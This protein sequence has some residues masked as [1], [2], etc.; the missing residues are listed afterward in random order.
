MLGEASVLV[1]GAGGLGS[2][3]LLYLAAAGIGQIGVIDDDS[4]DISNLQRQVLHDTASVGDAKV[5]S[6][7]RRLTELNPEIVIE[8]HEARLGV[9]NALGLIGEYDV[10]IDGSDNFSTRYLIGDVCEILGRPWVFG[11]IHRF[12]GQ[13]AT[14]NFDGSPNYRDLFPEAPPAELAP[15]CAEAGV[16]G[17]LAGMVGAMA[18]LEAVRAL[19]G[20]GQPLTGRLAILDMLDRRW[21]EVGVAKEPTCPI[22]SA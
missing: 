11:S 1:V 2:P 19:T 12:E 9:D 22:C 20:W 5:V 14:F 17:A 13:V 6:A 7:R 18:A 21:R 16:M 3:A 15:N 10:V 8:A 4:V